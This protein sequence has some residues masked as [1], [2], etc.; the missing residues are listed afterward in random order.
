MKK[1]ILASLV[2]LSL[3]S[4]VFAYDETKAHAFN[5]FYSKFTQQACAD[6]ELFI[7]AEDT[8]KKIREDEKFTILD[9]RTKGEHAIVSISTSNSIYIP[10]KDLFKKENL[11]K[12]PTDKT[13]VVVCHSGTRA[14]LAA[15]GLKQVGITNT[16]V[17]KGGFVALADAADPKNSPVK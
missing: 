4:T 6:S 3:A 15:I 10:I 5:D 1:T 7:S 16:R 13:I 17:L 9:V 11:D 12:L 8:M 2:T 14:T